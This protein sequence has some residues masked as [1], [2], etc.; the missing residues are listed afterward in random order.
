MTRQDR[1]RELWARVVP[2]YLVIALVGAYDLVLFGSTTQFNISDDLFLLTY[3]SVIH[4]LQTIRAEGFTLWDPANF[5]GVP[6]LGTG[7]ATPFNPINYLVLVLSPDVVFAVN[8]IF[9]AVVGGTAM[10]VLLRHVLGYQA[11]PAFF[12]GLIYQMLPISW[13]IYH[14]FE[15]HMRF[16]VACFPLMVA[17]LTRFQQTGDRRYA[18]Y[19]ALAVTAGVA[20]GTPLLLPVIVLALLLC[21]SGEVFERESTRHVPGLLNRTLGA[22]A[23]VVGLSLLLSAAAFLPLLVAF[24]GSARGAGP[25]HD[26]SPAGDLLLAFQRLRST[27]RPNLAGMSLLPIIVTLAAAGG[28]LRHRAPGVRRYVYPI[29]L[30]VLMLILSMPVLSPVLT[31]APV[32]GSISPVTYLFFEDFMLA[33]AAAAGLAWWLTSARPSWMERIFSLPLLAVAAWMIAFAFVIGA[34][35]AVR[36]REDMIRLFS[37]SWTDV[38]ARAGPGAGHSMS[39][40]LRLAFQTDRWGIKYPSYFFGGRQW[41]VLLAALGQAAGIVWLLQQ[42]QRGGTRGRGMVLAGVLGTAAVAFNW[43]TTGPSRSLTQTVYAETPLSAFIRG[44]RPWERI[45]YVVDPFQYHENEHQLF[46]A[47]PLVFGAKLPNGFAHMAPGAVMR[48]LYASETARPEGSKGA[49]GS[50]VGNRDVARFADNEITRV[51][52]TNPDSRVL[53]L[54]GVAYVV[55]PEPVHLPHLTLVLVGGVTTNSSA[56]TSSNEARQLYVYQNARSAPRAFLASRC[57]QQSPSQ[58]VESIAQGQTPLFGTVFAEE[59]GGGACA[60]RAIDPGAVAG[61]AEIVEYRSSRVII[62][63][64]P[65]QPAMLVLTDAYS[66]EWRAYVDGRPRPIV[67]VD[68]AFRGVRVERGNHV[69]AFV[70]RPWSFYVGVAISVLGLAWSGAQLAVRSGRD[71]NRPVSTDVT[72]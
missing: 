31:R 59:S 30:L 13:R 70:Y 55:S 27:V 17:G 62:D 56:N 24:L 28:L 72:G 51:F 19:S 37:P 42:R 21:A 41:L 12:G 23:M 26:W 20:V 4:Y 16:P 65:T 47:A 48:L 64:Q 10:Y 2:A 5:T 9:F 36:P 33:V 45:A 14:P 1:V 39:Q 29:G 49:A 71:E 25:G 3:P 34:V 54:L 38:S 7:I 11:L 22:W 53:D 40:W 32:L 6:H 35:F 68:V 60:D 66:P 52:L 58:I 15:V 18:I 63:V 67:R 69:V 50:W 44:L 46:E 43:Y 57:V 61:R 8:A